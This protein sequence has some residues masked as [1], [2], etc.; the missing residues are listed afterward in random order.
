MDIN[1]K[2]CIIIK[3][4]RLIILVTVSMLVC[5]GHMGKLS[6][7]Q[8]AQGERRKIILV[9]TLLSSFLALNVQIAISP[10]SFTSSDRIWKFIIVSG[11][12][13]NL[14]CYW[15]TCLPTHF[16]FAVY[17]FVYSLY[18]YICIRS[19]EIGIKLQ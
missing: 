2:E 4:Y 8:Q 19:N 15:R 7:P 9:H 16:T 6:H 10:P 18:H 11:K 1:L 12:G 13:F 17:L 14:Q 5:N 3:M